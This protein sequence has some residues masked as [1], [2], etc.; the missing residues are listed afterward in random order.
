[1]KGKKIIQLGL[2]LVVKESYLFGRNLYGLVIH[3]FLTLKRIKKE[4]DRSQFLLISAFAF[5]PLLAAGLTSILL[6][7]ASSFLPAFES[8]FKTASLVFFITAFFVF[9]A[10]ASWIGYWFVKIKKTS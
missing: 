2:L 9:L 7:L 1:M 6:W 4:R 10:L 5:S 8:S 3:P